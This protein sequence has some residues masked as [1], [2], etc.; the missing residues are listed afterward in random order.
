MKSLQNKLNLIKEGKGN[1]ELFLKEARAMFP[2]IV[3]GALTF[4][5]AIHNL[6]ERGILSE[7]FV[8]IG[9]QSVEQ[10]NW[11]KIFNEN[12]K[13]DLKKPDTEVEKMEVK[14][15]DYKDHKNSN[16]ISTEAILTGYYT[17]MKDPK[18]AEKTEQ[19]L[20]ELVVKNL[21]K[22]PMHYVK[23]GQ[24]GV[25][26]LGYTDKHPGLGATKE[27][28]GK[29]K[30]SGMEPV[31]LNES[32]HSAEA[33]LKIYK[34]ELNMLNKIKPTGEKQLKRKAELEKKIADLESK[35]NEY[36]GGRV[37][38][39]L[40]YGMDFDDDE[41]DYEGDENQDYYDE[42][43]NLIPLRSP[44][45]PNNRNMGESR[46]KLKEGYGMSLEDAMKQAY[47]E[48]LNGYV[49]HVEDNGDGTFKV[50]DWYD[51][52]MTIVSFEDG[53]K[54]N[55]RTSEYEMNEADSIKKRRAILPSKQ[56]GIA[57]EIPV[58]ST[59]D[60]IIQ[61]A[62]AEPDLNKAKEMVLSHIQQSRINPRSK[63]TM[64]YNIETAR[65][66]PRLDQY[67]AN[68]LLSYE[69]MSVTEGANKAMEKAVKEIEKKSELA[70]AEAKLHQVEELISELE[71]KLTMT[72]ADG[73]SDMVDKTKV[74]EIKRNLKFLESKKKRYLSEK[75]KLDKKY[76][77]KTMI[78]EEKVD[79]TIED[80]K[81]ADKA[82]QSMRRDVAQPARAWSE[83]VKGILASK[84]V[85]K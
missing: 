21:E 53:R 72:E 26:G 7:G 32:K 13:A 85:K 37:E 77:T 64:A 55:D 84:G 29:Y 41:E 58:V 47:E 51:S 14:G 82:M 30:S 1:K 33:D 31:K 20:K 19:Q 45:H 18:N 24:F 25:K 70:K 12:V 52:D 16:N 78:E 49:Q 4:D 50:S 15:Y 59:L 46:E 39:P 44:L 81:M 38:V 2:N 8:G 42:D 23:D 5:Q 65:T 62:W 35:M 27:V 54:F 74:K 9:N 10:P 71:N 75:A 63:K 34:S 56:K 3:T 76:G 11:F 40:N 69:K 61:Q 6:T 80:E 43:G 57:D 79:P 60:K 48:S 67:L 36:L 17:E 66:K 68:A 22:D 83:I 28:T 73:M